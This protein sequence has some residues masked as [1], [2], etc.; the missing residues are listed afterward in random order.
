MTN[1]VFDPA[2]LVKAWEAH[3]RWCAALSPTDDERAKGRK[4]KHLPFNG[5]VD[6]TERLRVEQRKAAEVLGV[7]VDTFVGSVLVERRADPGPDVAGAIERVLA[8]GFAF[9]VEACKDCGRDIPAYQIYQDFHAE[10][11][12]EIGPQR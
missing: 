6:V 8:T 1:P 7:D 2:A 5:G 11:C 10:H 12:P 9:T 4:S 3:D